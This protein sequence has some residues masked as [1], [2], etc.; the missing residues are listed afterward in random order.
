MKFSL[1]LEQAAQTM[2]SLIIMF[3][4]MVVLRITGV[5]SWS[6]LWITAP[7]WGPFALFA[8]MVFILS[9]IGVTAVVIK[10]FIKK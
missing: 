9:L 5:I 2:R 6:W 10:E 7:L 3:L 8:T 4:I 1:N